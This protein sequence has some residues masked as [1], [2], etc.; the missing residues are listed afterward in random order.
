MKD[1]SGSIDDLDRAIRLE[2]D[3]KG[4][5]Y[6]ERALSKKENKDYYGACEDFTKASKLGEKKAF[7]FIS[8]YCNRL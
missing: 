5:L 1:I 4:I 6:Y 3:E 2:F 8:E 7:Q